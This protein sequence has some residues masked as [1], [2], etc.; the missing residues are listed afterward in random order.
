MLTPPSKL[1][2]QMRSCVGDPHIFPVD[3]PSSP[4]TFFPG[5]LCIFISLETGSQ[6]SNKKNK[7]K[8]T[9]RESNT[10]PAATLRIHIA[11]GMIR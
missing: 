4:E 6:E 5:Y 2:K 1:I 3:A 8:Y 11:K 7:N 9:A 10:I